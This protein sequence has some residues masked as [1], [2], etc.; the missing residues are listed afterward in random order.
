MTEFATGLKESLEVITPFMQQI[1]EKIGEGGQ[2]M[3][4]LAVRNAYVT[5][6]NYLI[7]C[8]IQIIIAVVFYKSLVYINDRI[9]FSKLA[10]DDKAFIVFIEFLVFCCV[11][12]PT[13]VCFISNISNALPYLI[14]PEY[15]ALM[16]IIEKFKQ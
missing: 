2:F 1:A 7:H 12:V 16:D 10:N 13:I 5:G 9:E 6:V 14:N 8:I 15:M 4:A 11:L 3:F